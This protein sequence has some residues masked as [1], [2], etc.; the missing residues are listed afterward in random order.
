MAQELWERLRAT[1]LL[2]VAPCLFEYGVRS[3]ADICAWAGRPDYI[4]VTLRHPC[5]IKYVA[6]AALGDG[7]AARAAEAAKRDRYLVLSAEDSTQ[8]SRLSWKRLGASA[9]PG[10][11][12]SGRPGRARRSSRA[13]TRPGRGAQ[14]CKSG[15]RS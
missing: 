10:S 4:D 9:R 5:A 13:L 11:A 2:D 15:S 7:A 6:Q 8:R 12:C 14:Q 3:V 1:G